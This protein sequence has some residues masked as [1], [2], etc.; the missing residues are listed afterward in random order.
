MAAPSSFRY[1]L[2]DIMGIVP[3]PAEKPSMGDRGNVFFI[4]KYH[5][6]PEVWTF[7]N[8]VA[9]T[10]ANLDDISFDFSVMA[11]VLQPSSYSLSRE[12]DEV[13]A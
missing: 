5:S 1:V 8:I 11:G 9:P 6:V 7:N 10:E 13:A 3:S 4:G 12:V 2:L